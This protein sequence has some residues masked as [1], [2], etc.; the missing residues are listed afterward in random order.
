MDWFTGLFSD[1]TTALAAWGLLALVA[2]LLA[3]LGVVRFRHMRSGMFV[4]GGRRHRLAV[5]DATAIDNRRRLVLVRRDDVEHLILI[6]GHNDL[7]VEAG[8]GEDSKQGKD[9][10]PAAKPQR[11]IAASG[12]SAPDR[13]R[14]PPAEPHVPGTAPR[15]IEPAA[16][17]TPAAVRPADR[18][19]M[20]QAH[21]AAEAA[22]DGDS[23]DEEVER[24]LDG[25]IDPTARSDRT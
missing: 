4:A 8:I 7:V 5:L 21:P 18:P 12:P 3:V 22:P 20:P 16:S 17:S 19:A 11:P 24:L 9:A 23:L 25:L 13:P 15:R 6:G 10:G 14:K 2:L 1:P